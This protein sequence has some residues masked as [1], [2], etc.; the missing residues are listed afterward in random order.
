MQNIAQQVGHNIGQLTR[1][2]DLITNNLA[3]VNTTGY[4]RRT[5]SF[6]ALLEAQKD[7][8][9]GKTSGLVDMHEALDFS[10]G[11]FITTGRPLDLALNGPG[12]F[13]IEDTNQ[14]LYTRAGIFSTNRNG[15]LVDTEGRLVGGTGGPISIPPGTDLSQINVMPDGTIA[16]PQQTL[17]RLNIVD[18]DPSDEQQLIPMGSSTYGAPDGVTTQPD[19]QTQ[20]VQGTQEGSNVKTVEELVDMINVTRMYEAQVKFIT[21]QQKTDN[22]LMNVAMG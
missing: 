3:N 14:V 7:R 13:T 10:Q 17:G 9:D 5:N 4:K 15:Q 1:E 22:S 20:V 6:S 19:T 8:A 21:S 11:P 18:F 12:F 2:F 16:T